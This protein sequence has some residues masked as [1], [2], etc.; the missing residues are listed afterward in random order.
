MLLCGLDGAGKSTLL[1]CWQTMDGSVVSGN[2]T[3]LNSATID[4]SG[5]SKVTFRDVKSNGSNPRKIAH[6]DRLPYLASVAAM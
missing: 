3:N 1:V 5:R 6:P 4:L 2:A